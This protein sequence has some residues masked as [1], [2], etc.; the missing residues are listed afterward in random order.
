M[1]N[2][3]KSEVEAYAIFGN[4]ILG[5]V[6]D[7]WWALE[8]IARAIRAK[9]EEAGQREYLEAVCAWAKATHGVDLTVGEADIFDDEVAEIYERKK[10]DA[11]NRRALL[12]T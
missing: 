8:G 11:R 4:K 6:E 2:A 7:A 9:G 1:G 5:L 3:A 12:R 10:K